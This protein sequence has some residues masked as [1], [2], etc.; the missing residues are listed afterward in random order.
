MRF[1]I[2]ECLSPELARRL[3][4][5]GYDATSLRDRGR[6]GLK[7]A[8]VLRFCVEEDRTLVTQNAQNFRKLVAGIDAHLSVRRRTI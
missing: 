3:V 1:L 5:E 7:D 8:E 2:D 4:G 6:L